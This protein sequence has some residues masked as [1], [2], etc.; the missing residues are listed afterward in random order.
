SIKYYKNTSTTGQPSFTL[1]DD[2]F[3]AIKA[4]MVRG[5]YPAVG[6]LNNDGKDDLVI[7]HTSGNLSFYTNNA[8]SGTDVPVWQKVTDTLRDLNGI[9]L[10]STQFPAPFIYDIDND[11]KKD[12]L[13]GGSTGWIYLYKNTGNANELKLSYQANRL[14]NAKADP[15]TNFS[16]YSAPFVGRID[17]TS[18]DYLLMGSNSGTL[19]R[20]TGFQTG[21]ITAPFQRLDSGYS[22]INNQ[23]TS[24]SGYRSVP[25]VGDVDG[26]GKYEMFVGNVLG[27][28]RMY[29]QQIIVNVED[30]PLAKMPEIILYPNPAR[31]EVTVSWSAGFASGQPVSVEV[32]GLTGQSMAKMEIDNKTSTRI[33]TAGFSN[34][35]YHCVVTSG[36]NKE[37]LKLVILH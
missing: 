18:Q 35:L 31:N 26:D 21:N 32:F 4:E 28:L 9:A 6:D 22:H 7:G 23:L 8:A 20:Y 34:G 3:L 29:K 2:N 15:Q 19:Y 36:Q 10:D 24:Y 16:G 13:L 11:G 12:L 25:A 27:G 1:Q 37:V 5:A 17:N 33:S 14:G 30:G